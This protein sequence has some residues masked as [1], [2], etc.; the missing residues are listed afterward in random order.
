MLSRARMG[1]VPRV[2]RK[3]AWVVMVEFKWSK[4]KFNEFGLGIRESK[5]G[6]AR[7]VKLNPPTGGVATF[8]E[9]LP[10]LDSEILPRYWKLNEAKRAI[11]AHAN[12]NKLPGVGSPSLQT[13][14]D[15][16]GGA[17]AEQKATYEATTKAFRDRIRNGTKTPPPNTASM[18]FMVLE[19][20]EGASLAECKSAYRRL[21]L[22]HHPDQGGSEE[23]FKEVTTAWETIKAQA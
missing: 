5:C 7:I 20:S 23:K 8:D 2:Q 10:I 12:G 15:N 9:Y 11:V 3:N 17:T 6:R 22:E 16:R 14:Y 19:V 21:A 13:R 18:P 1:V 4:V